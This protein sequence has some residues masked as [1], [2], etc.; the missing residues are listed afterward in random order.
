DGGDKW[1]GTGGK[2]PYGHGGQHPTGI[3]VGG[4][5]KSRSAMKVAEE[6]HFKDYRTDLTLDVRQLRVALRRLRQLTR[7]GQATELDID[8]TVDET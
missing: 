2:S 8:E 7:T 4:P 3:R 1:V 5:P 6:R